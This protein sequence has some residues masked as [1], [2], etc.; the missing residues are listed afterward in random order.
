VDPTATREGL[1]VAT[2]G[3][4]RHQQLGGS[5]LD[6]DLALD[7]GTIAHLARAFQGEATLGQVDTAKAVAVIEAHFECRGDT[8][9]APLIA[10]FMGQSCLG[11]RRRSATR[12]GGVGRGRLG[13][14][15]RSVG[16]R[17]RSETGRGAGGRIAQ[18]GFAALIRARGRRRA[19]LAGD[20]R[21]MA[22]LILTV[23]MG[24][25]VAHCV[26]PPGRGSSG[27][28]LSRGVRAL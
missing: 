18:A 23:I 17:A 22:R 1:A 5:G 20:F 11:R 7:A 28:A 4:Y 13:R 6:R 16:S 9:V 12:G 15:T 19:L 8:N 27:G 2:H 10:A 26:F 24:V 3:A 21:S 25:V 14:G